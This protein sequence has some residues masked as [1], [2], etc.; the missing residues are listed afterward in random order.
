MGGLCS[1]SSD[2]QGGHQIL[3][4]GSATSNGPR[5]AAN[6][7]QRR[8]AAAVAA[9]NR[10]QKEQHR[11][12]QGSNPNRGKLAQKLAASSSAASAGRDREDEPL[13]WD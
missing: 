9:E 6:L 5:N 4:S 1:K 13:R 7:D 3:G 11:G 2:Q 8:Q 12:T 10:I